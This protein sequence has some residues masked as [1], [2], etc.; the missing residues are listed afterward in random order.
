MAS[1]QTQQ[2]TQGSS[3]ADTDQ[4]PLW[5]YVTKLEKQGVS[6]GCWEFKC[7]VCK[8]TRKGFYYLLDFTFY[9]NNYLLEHVVLLDFTFYINNYL[10]W[11]FF[12][13]FLIF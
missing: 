4:P 1:Q 7:N 2:E 8:D 13:I 10:F 6:G 9:I 5:R 3:S 11:I 12:N